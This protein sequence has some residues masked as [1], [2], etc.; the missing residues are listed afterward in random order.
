MEENQNNLKEILQKE[1]ITFS[2]LSKYAKVSTSTVSAAANNTRNPTRPYQYRI[3]HALNSIAAVG[4]YSIEDVFPPADDSDSKIR[5]EQVFKKSGIPTYTF[6]EPSEFQDLK[7]ALRTPGRGLVVEGPSGIG[8]TT[9]IL[10]VIDSLNLRN[11]SRLLSARKPTHRKEIQELPRA[12]NFGLVIIDDFH[13]LDDILKGEIANQVKQLA[14]EENPADKIVIVGINRTGHS[15]VSF[16]PDL[17]GRVDRVKFESNSKEKIAEL[18]LKGESVLKVKFNLADEIIEAANGSFHLTQMFCHAACLDVGVTEAQQ[19]VIGVETSVELIKQRVF[20]DIYP[21]YSDRTRIL[22]TGPVLHREGRAPYLQVLKYLAESK[23]WSIQID[24]VTNQHA[25]I[26]RSVS[27]IIESG[28]YD[29]FISTNSDFNDLVYYDPRTRSL[30]AED[31]KFVFYL[32]NL[33]WTR[34]AKQLGYTHA[35]FNSRY[36]IALSFAGSDRVF[37]SKLF[38]E[39]K[40]RQVSVFYDHNEQYRIVAQDLEEYLGPIYRTES[41]F[42]VA[43]LGKDYPDRV[44]TC[45]ESDEFHERISKGEVVAILMPGERFAGLDRTRR[46]GVISL[47]K[48]SDALAEIN[49][50]VEMLV[51]KL[52]ERRR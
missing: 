45:F 39:L 30:V 21:V 15:L 34:F 20:S 2:L 19:R 22:A 36:D 49:R 40:K 10:K 18:I 11:S 44:W 41:L 31:P 3:L 52:A 47:S 8:K 16:A 13:R 38:D 14:D 43:I 23:E 25:E 46:I 12:N 37:A 32:K 35:E 6:V 50:V 29:E 24:E 33:E 9:C 48:S 27:P 1:G 26:E 51:A 28:E 42:V 4:N 7:V 17:A 5:L